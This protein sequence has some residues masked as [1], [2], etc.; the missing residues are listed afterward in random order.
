MCA[1]SALSRAGKQNFVVVGQQELQHALPGGRN[2]ARR[3]RPL[4]FNYFTIVSTGHRRRTSLI[5]NNTGIV[6]VS[7]HVLLFAREILEF[8][9]VDGPINPCRDHAQIVSRPADAFDHGRVPY[10]HAQFFQRIVRVKDNIGNVDCRELVAAMREADF[11]AAFN[12]EFVELPQVVDEHI[13][14]AQLVGKSEDHVEARGVDGDRGQIVLKALDNFTRLIQIIPDSHRLVQAARGH[15]RLAHAHVD[16]RNRLRVVTRAYH[17]E[18]VVGLLEDIYIRD[19]EHGHL[20]RTEK[21]RQR[22]LLGA[23]GKTDNVRLLAA[24]ECFKMVVGLFVITLFA[25]V[26]FLVD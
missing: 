20:I 4:E 17:L 7:S 14:I 11:F 9:L 22:L 2:I 16:A 24:F 1:H 8:P 15:E 19:R 13:E 3:R 25:R 10:Q 23:D 5:V 12:R 18:M 21:C 6:H 26:V